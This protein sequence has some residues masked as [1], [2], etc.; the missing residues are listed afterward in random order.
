MRLG[1][2]LLK[3]VRVLTSCCSELKCAA[4]VLTCCCS[5]NNLIHVVWEAASSKILML[6]IAAPGRINMEM[7]P[8]LMPYRQKHLYI[9][10]ESVEYFDC[11]HDFK[12]VG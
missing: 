8:V 3:F 12:H 10:R 1:D 9:R 4:I 7:N 11:A 2:Q 6:S 5:D